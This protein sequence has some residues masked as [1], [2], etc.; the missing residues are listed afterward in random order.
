MARTAEQVRRI[1]LMWTSDFCCISWFERV[2]DSW[3]K[4]LRPAREGSRGFERVREGSRFSDLLEKVREG[5]RGFERV[6]EGSRNSSQ[7]CSRRFERVREGSRGFETGDRGTKLVRDGRARRQ[8]SKP[9][10]RGGRPRLRV[11]KYCTDVASWICCITIN[12]PANCLKIMFSCKQRMGNTFFKGS[13]FCLWSIWEDE[14]DVAD[15]IGLS[16]FQNFVQHMRKWNSVIAL[17]PF[18]KPFFQ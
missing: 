11:F 17:L 6:R 8:L 14:Q 9:A 1:A 15:R 7:T 5:S 13:P 4:I 10:A 3:R 16:Y 2:R 18:C 12:L